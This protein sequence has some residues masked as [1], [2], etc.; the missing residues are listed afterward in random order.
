MNFPAADTTPYWLLDSVIGWQGDKASQQ[1]LIVEYGTEGDLRLQSLPG[2]AQL[3]LNG[4][5]GGMQCPVACGVDECGRLLVLDAAQNWLWRVRTDTGEATRV[6]E[7]GGKGSDARRFDAPRGFALL[8]GGGMAVCDT[9]NHRVQVFSGPPYALVQLW[10][11]DENQPGNGPLEFHFP[12]GVAYGPDGFLYIADRGNGRIQ[13]VK[14]DGTQWSEIGGGVLASPTQVAVSPPGYVAVCDAAAAAQVTIFS[15]GT[16]TAQALT[17]GSAAPNTK[18][19]SVA[20]DPPGDLYAGTSKGLVFE[21][22]PGTSGFS[23]AGAGV[24]GLD[25]AITALAWLGNGNLI[26]S[27]NEQDVTPLQRLWSIP[28]AGAFVASGCYTCRPLDS[29]IENCVWHRIQVEGTVP[30]GTSLRIETCTSPDPTTAA[31]PWQTALFSPPPIPTA[32][33]QALLGQPTAAQTPSGAYQDPDGLVQSGPGRYLWLRITMISNGAA[34]P[35]IHGIRIYFPRQSYLQYLPAN[36]Q[37]DDQSRNFLDRFLPVFQTSFDGFDRRID[38]MWR[39]FDPLSTPKA[40]Y[41]WLAAWIALPIDPDWNWTKKRQVLDDAPAQYQLRGTVA[42]LQQSIQD[43]AGVQG[44][45]LEHFKLRRWPM[46]LSPAA[47]QATTAGSMNQYDARLCAAT[48]LWSRAFAA[49]LQVGKYSTIGSFELTGS[50]S[51]V[52]DPFTWGAAQFT[53]LFAADPYNPQTTAS[54]VQQ[55]VE[56]EKPAH[57]KAYYVPVYPRMRVGV[58]ASV[59]VDSYLSRITYTVLNRVGTLGY[60]AVLG[61]SPAQKQVAELG[62]PAPPITGLNTRLL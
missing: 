41:N 62:S 36:F 19:L 25:G 23:G 1:S 40:W 55:V 34:S 47:Q 24:S 38:N 35:E 11:A 10:G 15:P 39:L 57:T 56:R 30:A 17:A 37:D 7:I 22:T 48:P 45:I 44:N 58:Q 61:E 2:T 8:P 50:G 4:S 12:W 5:P 60:D 46:I 43:Y 20:F 49:R 54:K 59:G 32:Q 3:F 16:W 6:R 42:G 31:A 27:I 29:R 14:P 28:T 9:G 53:V 52:T 13:R 33:L 51:P 18:F 21:W 26:A